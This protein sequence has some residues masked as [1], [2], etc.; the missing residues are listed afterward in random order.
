MNK[1]W[2]QFFI[3]EFA[4]GRLIH[5]KVNAVAF[6]T[7]VMTLLTFPQGNFQSKHKMYLFNIN[8]AF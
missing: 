1:H 6:I 2:F 4:H 8:M 3:K 7:L 5:S